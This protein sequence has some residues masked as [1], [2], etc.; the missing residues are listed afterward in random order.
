MTVLIDPPRWPAHGTEFSHLV[1][2][3]DLTELHAVARRLG[4]SERAFD[5]DHYD[6]PARL[7]DRAVAL[8]VVPVEAKELTRRLIASGLRIRAVDRPRRLNLVLTHRWNV[9]L[10]GN[11]QLGAGLLARWSEP[12]RRYHD[13]RHLVGCLNALGALEYGG[14]EFGPQPRA[15]WLAAWFHDAMY[16]GVAGEDEEQSAG[17]AE[18]ELARAGLV[19][20]EIAE[21]GRLIRVTAGH[22]PAVDDAAGRVLCDAD[23][24]VL[25]RDPVGY[26][27]YLADVRAEYAHLDDA[28]F[29]AGRRAVVEQLLALDPLFRTRTGASR[30]ADAARRNLSAELRG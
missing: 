23:L 10:P 4:L 12:H 15:V 22:D 16:R 7:H 28:T 30:W 26:R 8:G 20:G 13:T 1:S 18:R 19:V 29:A 14:E 9:L 3:T 2:D 11:T 5:G 21:V 17:L 25:G 27:R 6:V 24:A